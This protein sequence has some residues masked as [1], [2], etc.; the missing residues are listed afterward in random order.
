MLN[1]TPAKRYAKALFQTSEEAANT[2][3]IH[4]D[5]KHLEEALEKSSELQVFLS[6][7]M[8]P[9]EKRFNILTEIFKSKVA[10][11]TFRFLQLLESKNRISLLSAVCQSFDDLYLASKQSCHAYISSAVE[12]NENQLHNLTHHLKLKHRVEIIPHVSINKDL[13]GGFKVQ[14]KDVIYDM[15]LSAQL[16]KFKEAIIHS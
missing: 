10:P 4:R 12:L 7:P 11:L 3:L 1:A 8:I 14:I 16:A 5:M 15:S 9:S 6:N 2:D 13:I